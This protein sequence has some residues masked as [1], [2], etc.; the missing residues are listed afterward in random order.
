[1]HQND[2]KSPRRIGQRVTGQPITQD[3]GAVW[4]ILVHTSMARNDG[5]I[6][7]M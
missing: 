1:M 5:L 6:V 3:F 7:T 4:T 2:W